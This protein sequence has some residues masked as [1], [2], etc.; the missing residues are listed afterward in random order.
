M[1]K[2]STK[3]AGALNQPQPATLKLQ[4]GQ[5]SL[6]RHKG[7]HLVQLRG[8]YEEMGRQHAELA[9]QVCGD[10]APQYF[11]RL[12]ENLVA[13]SLPPVA[14]V[15]GHSLKWL[16]HKRNRDRLGNRMRAHLGAYAAVFDVPAVEMERM[17]LVPDILHY[18]IG[19]A[20]PTYAAAPNCSALFARDGMTSK[21][22]VLIGRNFDFFGRGV[23]NANNAVIAMHPTG[24]QSFCWL[25]SLGVPGSAQGFNESGLFLGLHTQF[26]RDVQTTGQPVFKICHDIL[27]DCRNLDE[28]I[29]LI[30]MQPRMVGLTLFLVD[31]RNHDAASVGFS[32]NYL[33]VVRPEKDLLVQTNHY[34]TAEMR[35]RLVAPHPWQRNSQGRRRRLY[36][37]LEAE[38]GELTAAHLPG[39]LSDCW[40]V[41]EERKRLTGSIVACI[42]NA[43]S[44]V[45]SPEEDK[46]WL[47]HADYPV[48]HADRFAGFRIS[49]LLAGEADRYET[50]DLPGG[51]QLDGV[52]RAALTEYAEAWSAHL[53]QLNNDRAVFHLRR[54][55]ALAPEEVI[56]PRMAGVIL[57]KQKKYSQALPLLLRN[58]EDDYHDP[59]MKAEAQV[60]V[61][62]CLDLL[63]RRDE[64]LTH[65]RRAAA[66]A[67][68]PVSTAAERHLKTP[69]DPRQLFDVS[70]EFIVGTALARY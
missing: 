6:E 26:Q 55:A 56:F 19:R 69:F 30:Q 44:M 24:G 51:N 61:G 40:D 49:A 36:Q 10:I 42:N 8:S 1:K 18:L 50:D 43:Q 60:W 7:I 5:G 20:F 3:K 35:R 58:T 9:K 21:G 53:D 52:E 66:L 25:G 13:H 2:N 4:S 46:V 14:G 38:R 70:P 29:R 63:H 59:L 27:A 39:M 48:C 54:A 68:F 64:A 32:A 12:I 17:Y 22:Q 67:V 47:A 11:N 31:S 28:A 45:L 57:L 41:Y 62:R 23:W 65:Y 37:L 34:L 16:F 33:E 15:V